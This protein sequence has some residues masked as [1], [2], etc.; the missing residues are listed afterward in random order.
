MTSSVDNYWQIYNVGG[1][2]Q[3][4]LHDIR[5]EGHHFGR[6][7]VTAY[8]LA[9][10]YRHRYSDDLPDLVVG[11][12]GADVDVSL[13]SYL[14]NQLSRRIRQGT[15]NNIELRFLSNLHLQD[16]SFDNYGEEIRSSVIGHGLG[17]R[18]FR[19]VD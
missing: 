15:I 8:Q 4:I 18:M 7:F 17:Q 6:P 10:I 13:T 14:A 2:I 3:S 1:K 9:I 11:G 16:I 12:Q 5:A 19:S